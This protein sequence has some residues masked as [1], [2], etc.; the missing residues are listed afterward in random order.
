M[1]ESR[2]RDD[3]NSCFVCGPENPIGLNLKFRL[4]DD[5]CLGEFTPSRNH[6]GFDGMTH[7]GII[8]SVLDDVMANWLFLKGI[9]GYT[10]KCDVRFKR[11]LPTECKVELE[12]RCLKQRSKLI[13]M[14]GKAA[15]F[16]NGEVVA[17]CQ[18]SFML[19]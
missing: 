17:E 16:D 10:A 5:I 4:Q 6:C 3:A 11:P 1:T 8:F 14:A 15:R 2:G 7:G 9:R 19:E 18:A 12:G 13:L